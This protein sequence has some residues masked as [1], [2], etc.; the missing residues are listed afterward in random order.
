MGNKTCIAHFGP[1]SGS[2]PG[3]L[4]G[5][6][7]GPNPRSQQPCLQRIDN[8][9]LDQV[10]GLAE[11]RRRVPRFHTEV[12]GDRVSLGSNRMRFSKISSIPSLI[13]RKKVDIPCVSPKPEPPYLR[14][15]APV[16]RAPY[17]RGVRQATLVPSNRQHAGGSWLGEMD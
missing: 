13:K 2:H 5:S 12:H 11:E 10:L 8:P 3:S 6:Y 4:A 1:S 17:L 15:L 7:S 14:V 9:I 16:W